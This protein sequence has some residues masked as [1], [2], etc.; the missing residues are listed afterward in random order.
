MDNHL[1]QL[2]G[3]IKIGEA[4]EIVEKKAGWSEYWKKY[5]RVEYEVNRPDEYI[6]WVENTRRFIKINYPNEFSDFDKLL[7]R[8]INHKTIIAR[9]NALKEIQSLDSAKSDKNQR[10]AKESIEKLRLLYENQSMGEPNTHTA[11]NAY[12]QWYNAAIIY[13]SQYYDGTNIDYQRFKAIDNG[14]NGYS[15]RT[16]YHQISGIYHVLLNNINKKMESIIEKQISNTKVFIVHGHDEVM[17]LSVESFLKQI[18]LE[19]IILNEQTSQSKTVIEKLESY[20]DVG[21]AVILLSPCDEGCSKNSTKLKPRAR[22]NVILELGYFIGLL[23]RDKVCILKKSEVEEP[24]DFTGIIYISFEKQ[25]GWKIQLSR[26]LKAAGYSI[27]L[28]KII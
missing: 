6:Q 18:Q 15:L 8:A 21:F 16:T 2:E 19:P 28:N 1:E 12:H 13:F 3:L 9:L 14:G 26:E 4:F 24:S 10:N 5:T 23:G 17:K 27:D 7:N 22:Q 25:D 11:I 20:S